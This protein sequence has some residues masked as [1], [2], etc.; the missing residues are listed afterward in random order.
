MQFGTELICAHVNA[1]RFVV[2]ED[3]AGAV[4]SSPIDPDF[5][6]ER[7]D[8]FDPALEAHL[9]SVL[10]PSGVR[11]STRL[12]AGDTAEALGHLAKT[13]NA[14]MI[15]VGTHERGFGGGVQEFFNRSIAVHLAHRQNR[16]VVVVPARAPGVESPLPWVTT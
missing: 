8:T 6:D 13:V 4:R 1:G 15:V 11:W 2:S 9:A 16:P 3:S 14:A 5:H 12:L 7:E 10:G